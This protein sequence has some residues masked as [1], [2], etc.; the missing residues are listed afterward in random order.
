MDRLLDGRANGIPDD[1]VAGATRGSDPLRR[2]VQGLLA[3]YLAPV[4][5]LVLVVGGGLL[6]LRGLAAAASRL[7][8]WL[9]GGPRL[10]IVGVDR[11]RPRREDL[12][13]F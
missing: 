7:A 10:Q 3:L 13:A 8:C 2:V 12:D 1:D 9:S 4:F 5:L 11:S 6:A